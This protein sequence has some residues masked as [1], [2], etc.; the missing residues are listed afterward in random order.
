[1]ERAVQQLVDRHVSLRSHLEP[2]GTRMVVAEQLAVELPY[3][4]LSTLSATEREARQ[5]EL[6]K[7]DMPRAYDLRQGPLFRARSC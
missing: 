1:L 7:A 5:A 4:D 6:L 2:F 3:T